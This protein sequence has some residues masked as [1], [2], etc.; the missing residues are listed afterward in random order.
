MRAFVRIGIALTFIGAGCTVADAR[1]SPHRH[2]TTHHRKTVSHPA[3][4]Y[5]AAIAACGGTERWDV[6]D[7]SDAGAAHVNPTVVNGI[8]IADL[9]QLLPQPIGADGRMQE[10]KVIYR[11]NGILRLF[12]H[13]TDND[14]HIVVADDSTSR[15][16]TGHSMVVEV[17]DPSCVAGRRHEFGASQF[18]PQLRQSQADFEAATRTLPRNRDLGSRNIPITVVGVLFFDFMHG[19]TGHGLPHPSKDADRRDKV[20]ELHP[21]LCNDVGAYRARAGK[22]AC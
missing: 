5:A 3:H 1:T 2:R 18:L 22:P 11:I 7:G 19:Q 15:F 16:S 20:V 17:P 12:K 10:E 6:K 21:V 8:T 14:Y 13:E 9:N 4:R